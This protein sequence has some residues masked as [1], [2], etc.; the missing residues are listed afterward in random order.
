MFEALYEKF[1]EETVHIVRREL[2][3]KNNKLPEY[4]ELLAELYLR[5]GPENNQS[6][7]Q[8]TAKQCDC[9]NVPKE[10]YT[11]TGMAKRSF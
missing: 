2:T 3:A 7:K 5:Q 9:N 10:I 8:D 4:I 11:K 6:L 1:G